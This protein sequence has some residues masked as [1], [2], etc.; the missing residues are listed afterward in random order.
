MKALSIRQPWAW[1]IFHAGKE[2][3]NRTWKTYFR[4]RVLIHASKHYSPKE[5]KAAEVFANA[6]TPIFHVMPQLAMERGGVIGSVEIVD[7]V[8]FS[9]SP[10]F[11]GPFGFVLRNP[12]PLAFQP[13]PGRL[14]LFDFRGI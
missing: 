8:R 6:F 2:I 13:G 12:L 5:W 14:G 3:E 10:W 9:R 11:Q 7:C 4:G 1:M